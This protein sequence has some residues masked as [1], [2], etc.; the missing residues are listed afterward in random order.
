[1]VYTAFLY[2]ELIWYSFCMINNITSREL[3]EIFQNE[4]A[5]NVIVDIRN[6][7]ELESGKIRNAINIPMDTLK[8]H[9]DDLRGRANV[10]LV[11]RSGKRS[12]IAA[13]DLEKQNIHSVILK[14]GITSWEEEG[15]PLE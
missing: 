15:L 14:G 7:H 8:E 10:Y 3:S 2:S 11:C 12:E 13:E 1:M 9:L 4:D 5:N 6:P